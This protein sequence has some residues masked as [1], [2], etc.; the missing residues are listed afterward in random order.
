[1]DPRSKVELLTHHPGGGHGDVEASGMIFFLRR[2]PEQVRRLRWRRNRGRFREKG[3]VSGT[4]HPR[5]KY[6]REVWRGGG[7]HPPG[8]QVAGEG[9]GATPGHPAS[10]WGPFGASSCHRVSSGIKEFLEF[11]WNFLSIFNFHLFLQCTDKNRHTLALGTEL[12]G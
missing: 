3:S 4:F 5:D 7:P 1:M 2:V 12:V 6:R 11:F 8:G 9:E 10:W